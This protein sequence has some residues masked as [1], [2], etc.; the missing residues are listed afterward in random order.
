MEIFLL[1]NLTENCEKT[2]NKL[3]GN[4]KTPEIEP[5]CARL[6]Q[7]SVQTVKSHGIQNGYS[8][9]YGT[10]IVSVRRKQVQ[11]IGKLYLEMSC[12]QKTFLTFSNVHN[13]K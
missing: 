3:V 9:M 6:V 10:Q 11:I 5:K 12:S 1:K 2:M 7:D 4:R 13:I 8:F